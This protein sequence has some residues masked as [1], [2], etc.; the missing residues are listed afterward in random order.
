MTIHSPNTQFSFNMLNKAK[1]RRHKIV[2]IGKDFI[3]GDIR[4]WSMKVKKCLKIKNQDNL[5]F[6]FNIIL[7]RSHW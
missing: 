3:E 7:L 5:S 1:E 4:A 2:L 6:A